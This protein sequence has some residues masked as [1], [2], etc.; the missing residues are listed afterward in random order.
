LANEQ[1]KGKGVGESALRRSV[2]PKVEE[3][4]RADSPIFKKSGRYTRKKKDISNC[5]HGRMEK[6]G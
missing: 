6:R 3:Q 2:A 1:K 4:N 5:S